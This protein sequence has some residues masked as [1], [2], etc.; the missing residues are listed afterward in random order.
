MHTI[1]GYLG[2]S[3][4]DCHHPICSPSVLRWLQCHGKNAPLHL[5]LCVS[6]PDICW[7][8]VNVCQRCKIY[9]WQDTWRQHNFTCTFK[10]QGCK[11]FRFIPDVTAGHL[12]HTKPPL[13]SSFIK[14]VAL[15]APRTTYIKVPA[16]CFQ[17]VSNILLD[18]RKLKQFETWNYLEWTFLS[19]GLPTDARNLGAFAKGQPS[20]GIPTQEVWKLRHLRTMWNSG[21]FGVWRSRTVH[22]WNLEVSSV[23]WLQT[24]HKKYAKHV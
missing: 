5:I 17:D 1:E 7:K 13:C 14:V 24:T 3:R 20:H 4:V 12:A 23:F 10:Y 8:M 22:A 19:L 9:P 11:A 2:N 18:F 16:V 6:P 21:N 15:F